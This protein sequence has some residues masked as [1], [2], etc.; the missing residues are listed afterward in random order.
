MLGVG[1]FLHANFGFLTSHFDEF[2]LS[3]EQY[4]RPKVKHE[5][6]F[7]LLSFFCKFMGV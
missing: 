6:I 4:C 3:Y 5:K 2:F 1:F 7:H